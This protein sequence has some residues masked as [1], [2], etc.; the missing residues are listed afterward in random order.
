MIGATR[1]WRMVPLHSLCRS[2]LASMP[3]QCQPRL[4]QHR[5]APRDRACKATKA[6]QVTILRSRTT[7]LHL[8]HR[9]AM[10]ST[11]IQPDMANRCLRY[12]MAR[13]IWDLPSLLVAALAQMATNRSTIVIKA[14]PVSTRVT[15][16]TVDTCRRTHQRTMRIANTRMAQMASIHICLQNNCPD[17][18]HNKRVPDTQHLE[19]CRDNHN[20]MVTTTL[21]LDHLSQ[22]MYIIKCPAVIAPRRVVPPM[23][24]ETLRT[25][26]E[27]TQH[28][29]IP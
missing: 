9:P 13:A 6:S 8:V 4:P 14:M 20:G 25:L 15:I 24:T 23:A 21:L 19:Q 26:M 7:A 22:A 12:S 11:L 28:Q 29:L 17:L 1:T 5:P 10:P 2:I 18:Q 16:L 3:G 27:P